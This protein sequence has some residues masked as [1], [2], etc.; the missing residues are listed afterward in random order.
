MT[1]R[2]ADF[3]RYHQIA[4]CFHEQATTGGLSC[5]QEELEVTRSVNPLLQT[6]SN[7]YD[8]AGRQVG[9]QKLLGDWTTTVYDAAGIRPGGGGGEGGRRRLWAVARMR[10][11]TRRTSSRWCPRATT[12]R[13]ERRRSTSKCSSSSA[14]W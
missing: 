1:T 4:K 11:R 3:V 9:V 6:T 2:W 5:W 12:S 10:L 7:N 13:S 14:V 8:A